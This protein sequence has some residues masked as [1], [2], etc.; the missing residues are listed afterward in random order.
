MPLSA[1][2][3]DTPPFRYSGRVYGVLHNDRAALAA[4]GSAVDAPPYKGAPRAPVLY[5]KP[6][7]TWLE[8]GAP[9]PVP[10]GGELEIGAGVG[11]VIG[12]A[13]CALGAE[14]ALALV[15]GAVIVVDL[16]VPHDQWYRPQIPAKARDASCVVGSHVVPREAAG[17]IASLDVRVFVDGEL[18][19]A[20]GPVDWVRPPARLLADVTDFMTLE[21]GD[22]LIAGIAHG[23][24][25]VGAGRRV[26]VEVERLGR[27]EFQTM[28]SREGAA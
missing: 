7:N 1:V 22:L 21:P 19:H 5:V 14:G 10:A 20:H 18:R 4:L 11:L 12:R 16:S 27:V 13:A 23:A 15:S 17:E 6:R 24:P 25:R 2:V 28:A 26:V 3:F 8:P 9:V